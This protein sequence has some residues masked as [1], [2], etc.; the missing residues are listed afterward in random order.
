M[1]TARL[2]A[3]N[4]EAYEL[5][6]DEADAERGEQGLER[7]PVQEPDDAALDE[8]AD[9]PG[10]QEGGRYRH[11]QR[12]ADEVRHP[13][14][15]DVGRVGAEHHQLAVRHVDDAHDAEGDR[16]PDGDQH[17]HGSEAEP[18]G[19]RLEHRVHVAHRVD[20][21]QGVGRRG[22]HVR[23][24]LDVAPV[25][26]GVQ[27]C[28]QAVVHHR[29]E[30]AREPLDGLDAHVRIAVLERRDGKRGLDLVRHVR[31]GL[32]VSA[33][34]EELDGRVVEVAQ[35]LPR[36]A[37]AHAGVGTRQVEPGDG[38]P[39]EPAQPVVGDDAPQQVG[40]DRFHGVERGGVQEL[41]GG[42]ALVVRF[43]DEDPPVALALEQAVLE[44]RG[45][46]VP[47]ARV[48]GREH[49]LGQRF[50][51]AEAGVGE[52]GDER[53]KGV[54]ARV[55][56]GRRGRHGEEKAPGERQTQDPSPARRRCSYS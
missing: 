30:A 34:A 51:L 43:D 15:H 55:G 44:Q 31:V 54:V 42:Q 33:P 20:L 26:G 21:P 47:H 52:L 7:P 16:Q 50:L 25:L 49:P 11:E 9:A 6:Q 8:H 29:V 53:T 46:H 38:A 13:E 56:R 41:E 45:Q 35:Q 4:T 32:H 36:G 14:L 12:D 39:Q 37:P 22:P 1:T 2:F 19:R 23:V 10:D 17:Q 18:E 48:P 27:Q 28:R 3:E 5:L 24:G 40:R